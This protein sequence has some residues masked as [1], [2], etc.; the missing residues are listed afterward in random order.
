MRPIPPA[1][2]DDIGGADPAVAVAL[3]EYDRTG[4]A[5]SVLVALSR[6]RVLIPVTAVAD[7]PSS[8]DSAQLATVLSTGRDGRRALLAFTCLA[9]LARCQP[10]ARPVPQPMRQA[11]RA[12]LR[13][14][15][16]ALVVDI[17]GPVPLT[18]QGDDL[19]QLAA[20]LVLVPTADGHTW[21]L[22]GAALRPRP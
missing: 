2:S 21:A 17:A 16:A 7:G 22:P 15:A 4:A 14:G 19:Q 6:S 3:S 11:A 8:G 13:E 12:A 18:I 9:T 1:G 10:T 5:G 20:G